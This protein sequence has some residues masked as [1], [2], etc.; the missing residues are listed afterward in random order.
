MFVP[1]GWID[2][3]HDFDRYCSVHSAIVGGIHAAMKPFAKQAQDG[4]R[5][6]A[7][8]DDGGSCGL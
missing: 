2:I 8:Q 5:N 1:V 4:V 3:L 7:D 6:T